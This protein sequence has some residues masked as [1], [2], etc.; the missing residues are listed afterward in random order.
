M[1]R[2]RKAFPAELAQFHTAEYVSF[3][4]RVRPD[5][6]QV[7]TWASC[8]VAARWAAALPGLEGRAGPHASLQDPWH[9]SA[10]R[11]HLRLPQQFGRE[12]REHNLADEDCPVFEGLFDFCRCT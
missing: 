2:P 6:Q 10:C 4:S 8:G 3:L 7:R 5:N 12:M 9:T 11:L 1:Q